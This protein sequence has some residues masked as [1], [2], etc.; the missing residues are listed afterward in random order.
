LLSVLTVPI[1]ASGVQTCVL[2]CNIL[3]EKGAP[4]ASKPSVYA[5]GYGDKPRTKFFISSHDND[6][7]M[8]QVSLNILYWIFS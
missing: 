8:R 7:F 3:A 5:A 6:Q 4:F 2:T 1:R